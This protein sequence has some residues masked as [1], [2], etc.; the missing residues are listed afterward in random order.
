FLLSPVHVTIPFYTLSL[1]DA[2]PISLHRDLISEHQDLYDPRVAKRILIVKDQS[3]ADYI[4]LLA[5]R[6]HW[7]R[8]VEER[9]EAYDAFLMPT[10]PIIA[11]RIR[12]LEDEEQYFNHNALILRNPSI[13]NFLNGCA[14]SLP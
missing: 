10:S 4:D 13:V 6:E 12:D 3:A 11:P 9:L 7:I 1:H 2:L 14:I 8:D 5:E